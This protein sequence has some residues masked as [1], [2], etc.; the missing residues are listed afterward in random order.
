MQL[1]DLKTGKVFEG[2]PEECER[3]T[4]R[5][6]GKRARARQRRDMQSYFAAHPELTGEPVAFDINKQGA[7]FVKAGAQ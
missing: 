7:T 6:Y 2:T 5:I 3:E 4:V 1:I